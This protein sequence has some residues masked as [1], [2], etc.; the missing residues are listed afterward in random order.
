MADW[1]LEAIESM[2]YSIEEMAAGFPL[3]VFVR[4][5]NPVGR[6]FF[7]DDTDIEARDG[8]GVYTF[9]GD[10]AQA[11]RFASALEAMDW[12][13]SSP[14]ARPTRRELD[15]RP[16]RPLTAFSSSPTRLPAEPQV[17]LEQ[18]QPLSG[19][20]DVRPRTP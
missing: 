18:E 9:T 13:K 5:P 3:V 11:K 4:D 6:W 15:G 14:N 20:L 2:G 8:M 10:P 1:I 17:L 12:W 19:D 7:H 16:N